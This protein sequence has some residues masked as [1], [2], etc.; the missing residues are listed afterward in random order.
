MTP[1]GPNALKGRS[2]WLTNPSAFAVAIGALVATTY[3]WAA[4]D[5]PKGSGAP[6]AVVLLVVVIVTNLAGELVEQSRLNMLRSLGLGSVAPSAERLLTA[7][8]EAMRAPGVSFWVVLVGFTTASLATAGGWWLVASPPAAMAMR[9]GSIGVLVAP[10]SAMTA[11]L[12]MVTRSRQMVRVLGAAGLP[13]EQLYGAVQPAFELRARLMIY[14]AISVVTPMGLV[15]E[16]SLHR[17]AQLLERLQGLKPAEAAAVSIAEADAG[18]LPLL[19]LALVVLIIVGACAWLSGH[20]LGAPMRE[21]ASETER[22]A[23][24]EYGS[25]NL[26]PSELEVWGVARALAMMETRLVRAIG[27]LD[28]TAIG[29]DTTTTALLEGGKT[30]GQRMIE[31]SLSL[32]A[33]AATTEGLARGARKVAGNAQNVSALAKQTLEVAREGNSNAEAFAS[34]MEQ[35]GVANQSIAESV[36]RLN[37]RVRQVGKV[38]EFIDSIADKSD[39]L[40]LNA[41]LEGHKAGE[42]GRGFVS[43]AA[44]MRQLAEKVMSSTQEIVQLISEIRNSTNA[45][46]M[47][48]EAGV[49]ATLATAG[50]AEGVREGFSQIV[51]FANHSSDAMASI[52]TATATQ[53]AGT[54]QLAAVMGQILSSTEAGAEASRH[55]S[56][57]NQALAQLTADLKASLEQ[58]QVK[59]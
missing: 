33:I 20:A 38:V 9:V 4:I 25:P 28:Q 23:R 51:E 36:L 43:V 59:S 5:F 52:S 12:V 24:G 3:T 22:L 44:E 39:L 45:A 27:Q 40:A 26:V 2:R 35:V 13:V 15:A 19:V 58:L 32:G 56:R 21:L 37:K 54:D 34:A 11:Y 48:T 57:T 47:A 14:A 1:N 17:A 53:Q 55:M 7:A 42:A 18:L 41:E 16:M 6:F 31:Q 8:R 46:V 30:Q 10:L 49:K 50:L 29:I